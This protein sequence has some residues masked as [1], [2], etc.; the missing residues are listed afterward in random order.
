MG[1]NKKDECKK[2]PKIFTLDTETR[3]LFGEIFR[4]GLYDGSRYFVANTFKEIK[5]TILKYTTEYD[6]HVFI[7][8][9]DF[10]LSKTIYDTI[11]SA[12]LKDSIFINNNVTLFKTS[13]A[14]LSDIKEE[15]DIVPE[16]IT[17]HDSNKL[18]LGRLKKI[19]KDFGLDEHQS[20]IELKDHILSLGWGRNKKGERINDISEYDEFESEGYY[21]KNVDP[22]E[23]QLNEYLRMDCISLYEV[24]NTLIRISGLEVE[25]FLRCPTTASLAMKVYSTNYPDDYEKAVSTNYHSDTGK[26]YEK[27]IRESYCGGRTEVFTPY[28]KFGFHYDVNSEYPFVMKTFKL[29]YGRPTMHDGYEAHKKFKYW[30][31]FNKGA[32]FLKCDIYIPDMF[33]PPLPVKRGKLIFPVGNVTGTWTFEEIKV[34]LEQGCKIRKIHRCLYFEKTAYL[35]KDFVE[36]FEEIKNTTEGAMKVFAK[37]MQNA[38]YGKF[39]M[40]RIRETILDISE[41]EKCEE[42]YQKFGYRYMILKNPLLPSGEFIKADTASSAEYIQPHIASYITSLARLV[43]YKG[44]LAQQEK[45]IVAYC[46]TDSVACE[47]KMDDDMI[48]EKEYGKW[49]LESIVMDGIFLQPKTYYEKHPTLVE[50]DKGLYLATDPEKNFIKNKKTETKKFKGIPSR[51]M[52][53]ITE[54]TYQTIFSKLIDIQKRL[55]AGEEIPKTELKFPLYKEKEEKRIKFAT[56]LKNPVYDENGKVTFDKKIEIIKS[57]NLAGGQKRQ[58]DYINNTSKAHVLNDFIYNEGASY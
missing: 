24:L 45:G 30:Y 29:P 38:L 31:N 9:L 52:D 39:G 58:M 32:G 12:S 57:L 44:L 17:F 42:R 54:E 26:Y 1:K 20:K 21:F 41:K 40:K 48:H 50:D 11:P 27:F 4:V 15:N 3:G 46:D 23:R 19:C 2:P 5:T 25:T 16:S 56:N 18:I 10:D 33:I 34:A 35:F 28:L 55:E 51:K 14:T 7:H 43:L 47:A 13:L 49:K 37:L 6:C 53:D 22:F 8:N 36:Y